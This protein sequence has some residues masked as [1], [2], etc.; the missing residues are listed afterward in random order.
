MNEKSEVERMLDDGTIYQPKKEA[1]DLSQRV[2]TMLNNG[3]VQSIDS[4][5]VDARSHMQELS[6]DFAERAANII[7]E[8]AEE[9]KSLAD[10]IHKNQEFLNT[11]L[12]EFS[13]RQRDRLKIVDETLD[14]QS[15]LSD[16]LYDV[17]SK[18]SEKTEET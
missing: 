14:A 11:K 7:N 1:N 5:V 17:F 12:E 15:S 16:G 4:L 8:T 3:L 6:E 2:K 13:K 10:I 18:V 9:L